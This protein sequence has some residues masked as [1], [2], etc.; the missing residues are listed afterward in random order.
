[1]SQ[2]RNQLEIIY[3]IL[4][5]VM[6]KGGMIKPTHLLYKSNLSHARMKEYI[7]QLGEKGMLVSCEQDGRHKFRITDQGLRFVA[8]YKKVRELTNA[9]GL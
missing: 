2:R 9:F 7:Q 8:D 6:D 3:D 1:M 5:A 4:Q